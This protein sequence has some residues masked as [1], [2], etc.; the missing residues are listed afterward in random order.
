MRPL[1][2]A[3]LTGIDSPWIAETIASLARLSEVQIVG[4]L[5]DTK[6][7]PFRARLRHLRRNVRR[8]GLSYVWYRVGAALVDRLETLAARVV[9]EPDVAALLSRAF[10]GRPFRLDDLEEPHRILLPCTGNLNGAPARE[11]LRRLGPD[12]GVVL[13][14]RI[15]RRS[16]FTI[17]RM[18]CLNLHLGKVPEY[19][20]LP[21]G[22]WELYDGQATAGVTVH[23]VDDG[24][25]T[26]DIVGED[27]V[28]IGPNDDPDSLRRKLEE[29][30][31]D[32]LV[33]CIA[34]L[35]AGRATRTPQR[36]DAGQARTL[37]T[38]RQRRELRARLRISSSDRPAWIDAGKT[39][40]HLFLYYGGT[41][42]AVRLV[43]RIAGRSR[44][45]VLL[46]HRV[47][48]L[49]EDPLTTSVR[50]F[51][52]HMVT[53]QEHYTVMSTSDLVGALQS[54]ERLPPGAVVI[55][56]D[57]CYRDVYAQAAPVLATLNSPA[58]C[59]VST[60]FIGTDRVF[61]HDRTCPFRLENLRR[62]DIHGLVRLGFE[63]G[64]H[65]VNH[66]DLGASPDEVAAR[67]LSQSKRDLEGIVGRPVTLFS[68]PFGQVSNVR[69]GTS[70]L[71]RRSGYKAMFSAY[72]GHVRSGSNPFDL[73]RIGVSGETRPLDLLMEIEG[74]SLGVLKQ[75]WKKVRARRC[76]PSSTAIAS[77]ARPGSS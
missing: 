17:P 76:W 4:V 60:G 53:L 32:L 28:H 15:L 20:G 63:V 9:H 22:F 62:D 34:D 38:R 11:M 6:P 46:Y 40:L 10:P 45:R 50:R 73:P 69:N 70:E 52:E 7:A 18:G 5:V 67:E 48:D 31:A 74:L 27:E 36:S 56:F 58:C 47:N 75:R 19:R 68:Y 66:V 57:D 21:P 64:S 2:L 3:I 65:T 33:R 77:P 12:F 8:Q 14:T 1:K 71:V 43:R 49:T 37:P 35:A 55:H 24:L 16:T 13:G 26:G 30:G 42:H 23:F 25:D 72:G 59:F 39:L 41:F 29:R 61:P 44:A 54:G 51:A